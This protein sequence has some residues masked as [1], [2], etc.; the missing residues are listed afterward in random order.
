MRRYFTFWKR[1]FDYKG[2]SDRAEYRLP[3]L[4]T[5]V[6]AL[7]TAA[8]WFA[9]FEADSGLLLTGGLVTGVLFTLHIPPMMALTVRRLRDAGKRPW[10]AVL[11]CLAGIGT[12]VVMLI[13]L[14]AV[15]G[16]S[17]LGNIHG[18]VYGPPEYFDPWNNI[19]EDIYGPPGDLDGFDPEDNTETALYGPPEM[20]LSREAEEASEIASR[21]A[22]EAAGEETSDDN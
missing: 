1:V 2:V 20:L 15:S 9:G 5:A 18:N 6:L 21:R 10:L 8:L 3:L 16:Y 22:A 4:V 7:L 19:N 13:C 11:S 12:I 17:P 14:L